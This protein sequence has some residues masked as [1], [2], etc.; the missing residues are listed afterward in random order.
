MSNRNLRILLGVA[1]A[2]HGIALALYAVRG[3]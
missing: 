3:L 2:I 1:V